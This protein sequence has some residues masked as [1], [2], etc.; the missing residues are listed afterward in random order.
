MIDAHREEIY[1]A[2]YDSELQLLGEELVTKPA[3]WI[4]ALPE[5]AELVSADAAMLPGQITLAPRAL[6]GAIGVIAPV[7][8]VAVPHFKEWTP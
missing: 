5:G 2:I 1:A 7:F 3:A 8:P 4:A 6:A